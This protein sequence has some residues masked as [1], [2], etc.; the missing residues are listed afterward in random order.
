MRCSNRAPA[1][2]S[3]S[4]RRW[5]WVR[6]T[7]SLAAG[8]IRAYA[9]LVPAVAASFSNAPLASVP[10]AAFA[11]ASSACQSIRHPPQGIFGGN[12]S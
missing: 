7:C 1:T 8:I 10:D 12:A 2:W 4:L 11:S 9:Y 3:G 6:R 5:W